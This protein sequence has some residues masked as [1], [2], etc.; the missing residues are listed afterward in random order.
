MPYLIDGHNLIH[1]LE[2]IRLDNPNDEAE[3]VIKLRGFCA[4]RKKKAVIIFDQGLPGGHSQLS[5]PSVQVIFASYQQTTADKII[6]E[7]ISAITDIKGWIVVSSD[8]EVLADAEQAGIMGMR[9]AQFAQ[10]L[11]RPLEEKPHPSENPNLRFSEKEVDEW[12]GIFGAEDEGTWELES[13]TKKVAQAAPKAAETPKTPEAPKPKAKQTDNDV[14]EWLEVFGEEPTKA[15]TEKAK[16]II[17]HGG[18]KPIKK[19][20]PEKDSQVDIT[21]KGSDLL[22]NKNSVAAWMEIFGKE[23]E[24]REPTDP[25][26]QRDDPEKQG[27]YKNK[28]GKY[29]PTVHKRMA[30][31]E[32]IHLNRGEVDAWMDVFG[33]DNEEKN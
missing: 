3:L 24:K 22:V 14:D 4:R 12:M 18:I 33:F 27:R 31:S 11:S 19:A 16:R 7:R 10:I 20:D 28:D 6:R 17:P 1:Y 25:A 30:T 8:N 29:E 13:E 26:F 21:M 23:D 32:D 5:T 9:C 2:D 15:P